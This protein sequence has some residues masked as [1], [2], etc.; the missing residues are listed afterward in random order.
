MARGSRSRW[1]SRIRRR[2]R[3]GP[4][5]RLYVSSRFDGQVHRLIDDDHAEVYRDRA[6]RGH[7]P[8]VRAGRRSVRRRQVRDDSS[9]QAGSNG[10]AVRDITGERRGV[11]PGVWSG[12]L[13]VC[14]GPDAC[15]RTTSIYRITPDRLVDEVCRGFGRPQGLAFDSTGTLYVVEALAGGAGLYRVDWVRR[16][17]RPGSD[18][19]QT[20]WRNSPS[21]LHPRLTP[22]LV[23]SAPS[24]VGVA[25]APGGGLVVASAKRC[26][27][28]TTRSRRSGPDPE[29]LRRPP[30]QG[31]PRRRSVA[32][33]AGR[34]CDA[35]AR[36]AWRGRH[37]G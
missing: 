18:G 20:T 16:G 9:R 24:L 33:A 31:N 32:P 8:G 12:R 1:T 30:A 37:Q 5:G 34:V 27:G 2:W 21:G 10:R 13:S 35:H 28:S 26:G 3:S 23:L 36:G 11:S 17:V 25:I 4:D 29:C 7:R 6:G 15:R 14:G 19:G 22:E